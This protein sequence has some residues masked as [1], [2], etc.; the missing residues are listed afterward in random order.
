MKTLA[1]ICQ[2]ISLMEASMLPVTQIVH[3]ICRFRCISFYSTL[4]NSYRSH[5][6]FVGLMVD[7]T[8]G[9]IQFHKSV[10]P[11]N[12]RESAC[13]IKVRKISEIRSVD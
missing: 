3:S 7:G 12:V 9:T 1:M 2:A 11:G 4:R 10:F 5:P 13:T 6:P 8:V